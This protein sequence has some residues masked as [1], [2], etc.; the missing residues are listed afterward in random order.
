MTPRPESDGADDAPTI[1]LEAWDGPWP[2]DD[3]DANFK[4][5]VAAYCRLDPLVTLRGMS[6]ATDIPI[7]ALARYV[8]ARWA[9][10]GSDGL[11]EVGP[12][13]VRRLWEPIAAA[14]E[15]GDDERRLAAYHQLRIMIGWLKAPLDDPSLYGP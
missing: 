8:L 12:T 1:R 3:A 4:E 6:E 7:G 9:A 2:A 15:S 14:E 10:G 11:L 5:D 13:M